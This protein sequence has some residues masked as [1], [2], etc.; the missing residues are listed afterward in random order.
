MKALDG[1]LSRGNQV[2]LGLLVV[3]VV[4]A[5][6]VFW[7]R[8][9]AVAGE[10]PFF[11]ELEVDQV[12]RVTIVD[13]AGQEIVL[14]NQT[15]DWVLPEAG[16]YACRPDKVSEFLDQLAALKTDRLVTQTASSHGRLQVAADAYARLV[17]LEMTDGAR[18]RLYLGSSP[19]YSVIHARLAEQDEVYLVSGLAA[20]DASALA[21]AWI[22]TSYLSLV[23]DD[24]V[25][26]LLD[27]ANGT[28]SLK[29]QGEA[30][31]LEGL[32]SDETLNEAAVS[33]LVSR[34]TSVRMLAP[35]GTELL[36]EY[37]IATPS[38][39]IVIHTTGDQG[40][41]ITLHVGARIG[42]DSYVCKSSESL[43]YVR[44]AEY[45]AGDWVEKT[46][47]DLLELPP[48][49]TPTS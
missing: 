24:V 44:V 16:D 21:S 31:S 33:S 2:L 6:I 29:K 22:D 15:G 30:W 10:E 45:T 32:A 13:D 3:Q 37:G 48:T 27:N 46:R 7:P 35:L 47:E 43:Y 1:W 40:K 20:S 18:H 5:A 23:Q 42:D 36:D 49:P 34:V 14:A 19:N 25:A 26:V 4:V 41:T 8:S 9:A 39:V 17:E 12:A 11:P 38:A 28:L